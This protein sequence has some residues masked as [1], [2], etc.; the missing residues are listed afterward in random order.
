MLFAAEVVRTSPHASVTNKLISE[1]ER[2]RALNANKRSVLQFVFHEVR[3]PLN[4]ITLGISVVESMIEKALDPVVTDALQMMTGASQF[5]SDTLNTV[6][7]ISKVEEGAMEL[8]FAPFVLKDLVN[9]VGMVLKGQLDAKNITLA[10]TS[11][12]K[13]LDT[14]HYATGDGFRLEHVLANF[15]SNAIKFSPDSSTITIV[16]GTDEA[17]EKE[18]EEEEARLA[19]VVDSA[20]DGP[21]A[22]A[23]SPRFFARAANASMRH[24][25]SSLKRLT[26]GTMGQSAAPKRSGSVEQRPLPLPV[27]LDGCNRTEI[28]WIE[29]I[30]CDQGVGIPPEKQV[31]LFQVFSQIDAQA[32][33]QGQGSGLG[34]VFAQQ[35]IELHGGKVVFRS[36]VGKGSVFG[37]SIPFR[38]LTAEQMMAE[39][40]QRRFCDRGAL[41]MKSANRDPDAADEG[42][43]S[44]SE[45]HLINTPGISGSFMRAVGAASGAVMASVRLVRGSSASVVQDSISNTPTGEVHNKRGSA[46]MGRVVLSRIEE[47]RSIRSA[48]VGANP[49]A[50]PSGK[51]VSSRRPAFPVG[52]RPGSRAVSEKVPSAQSSHKKVRGLSFRLAEAAVDGAG[53]VD[54]DD[55]TPKV[56]PLHAPAVHLLT[57]TAPPTAY[58]QRVLIVDDTPSNSRMLKLLLER[59]GFACDL[60]ENGEIAVGLVKAN[61]DEC[62]LM[63]D[64]AEASRH[65][66]KLI[67]MD[68]QMPVMD[69]LEA[70]KLIRTACHFSSIIIG[71]SGN[72]DERDQ[73][74]FFAAGADYVLPK[75]VRLADLDKVIDYCRYVRG[76]YL[77]WQWAREGDGRVDGGRWQGEVAEISMRPRGLTVTCRFRHLSPWLR[78]EMAGGEEG[79]SGGEGGTWPR[80]R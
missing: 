40:D 20:K 72:T 15:L 22:D 34:L 25:N 10:I 55:A 54:E 38:V 59:S 79:S 78:C 3:V 43:N 41:R 80:P 70:T 24:F 48:C 64:P 31:M 52:S 74:M 14:V 7:S 39:G 21:K 60:A 44:I 53:D 47:Q 13:T 65:A 6:L 67:F 36:E 19:L 73:A 32:L 37:F 33:Q 66:Y 8:S 61:G 29:I 68:H 11:P 9:K 17:K 23:M 50:S 58:R 35:I 62:H 27:H 46:G 75:P 51:G 12:D 26:P 1:V 49:S 42:K 2:E 63:E 77:S 76:G 45:R 57:L 16:V 71:C 18:E 4:T 30:V 5:M 56:S 69:G 28:R